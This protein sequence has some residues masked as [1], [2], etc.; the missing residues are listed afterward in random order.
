MRSIT[1]SARQPSCGASCRWGPYAS[2]IS[3][4]CSTLLMLYSGTLK[5]LLSCSGQVGI[6]ESAH[7]ALAARAVI[8]K[9]LAVVHRIIKAKFVH[10]CLQIIE[11]ELRHKLCSA[12]GAPGLRHFPGAF[13]IQLYADRR[14]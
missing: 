8:L 11:P 5:H 4:R 3:S 9:R 2:T 14:W 12:T 10:D 13:L 6:C 7:D 1:R